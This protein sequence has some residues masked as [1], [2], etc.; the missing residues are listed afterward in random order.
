MNFEKLTLEKIE[1]HLGTGKKLGNE[2]QWQC[3]YCNDK[4]RD[5][6]KFNPSKGILFCFASNGEHSKQVLK[7]M[8]SM[9][10]PINTHAPKKKYSKNNYTTP[11][12]EDIPVNV[13]NEK[14]QEKLLLYMNECN[15][16]LL[17]HKKSLAFIEKHRGIKKDTINFC[18]IGIDLEEHKWVIPTFKYST[19][20]TFITG[21]EFRPADFSK[22][23][24]RSKGTPTSM[25]MINCYTPQTN[26]L[27]IVEGYMDGYALFQHLQ[28][29]K[30]VQYYHIV[31][32]SNGVNSL[33]KYINQIEFCKYKKCYLYIDNDEVGKRTAVKI[34][35]Q[36]P[37]M[38][39]IE[40]SCGCKDFNDH[41]LKCI[42]PKQIG[43]SGKFL[44]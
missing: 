39:R 26:I 8:Y 13:Y 33:L 9:N 20:E 5:N 38:K 34:L 18:G 14:E 40:M 3:P 41:Y 12:Q 22:N 42:R 24:T 44:S 37:F 25:A 16:R 21:F 4:H 19:T 6:L 31:T 36:Y 17:K 30:Q 32:P 23:I 1:A 7:D 10:K 11:N 43:Q 15:E 28:E 35:E 29:N 2:Y 27:A